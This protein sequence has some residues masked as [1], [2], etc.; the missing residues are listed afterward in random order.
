MEDGGCSEL[1]YHDGLW[2][3]GLVV[4]QKGKAC[5][6]DKHRN[7]RTVGTGINRYRHEHECIER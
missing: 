2:V 6:G 5:V 3:G 4:L 7:D 1:A